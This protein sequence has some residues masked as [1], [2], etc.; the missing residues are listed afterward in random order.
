MTLNAWRIDWQALGV[1]FTIADQNIETFN[2]K[3]CLICV[4]LFSWGKYGGFGRSTR[5]LG[6]ELAARGIQVAA[7]VPRRSGQLAVENL[8]GIEVL[9]FPMHRPLAMLE[10]FRACNADVYHSQNTSLGTYLAQKACPDKC[11][12]ITFRDP[13]ETHD[14]WLEIKNPSSSRLRTLLNWWYEDGVLV[15]RAVRNADA[16]VSTAQS[17]NSKLL[18][19]YGFNAPLDVMPTPIALPDREV[20]KSKTPTACY[21]G[22]LDPRKRPQLFC[23]LA[24]S[25]P[26]VSFVVIGRSNNP[27]WERELRKHY[28]ALTNL[29]FVGFV[30][31]FNS[32]ELWDWLDKSWIYVNTST[33]EGLPTAMLEAMAHGC[34]VLSCLNP[35]N[36]VTRFG[37]H[38]ADNHLCSGLSNLLANERWRSLGHDGRQYVLAEHSLPKSVEKHLSL[39]RRL[40]HERNH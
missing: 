40:V 3:V 39:Y 10:L 29:R 32:R 9:G 30:D 26:N 22:R 15:R 19:K 7:V 35:D 12:V 6:R 34:A 31:Q 11:H 8:D 21:V 33:R 27:K 4:E 23:E 2:V 36:L 18:R 37:A 14:W 20:A 24:R 5:I 17:V 1:D 16:L 25:F 13:K 28:G 38:V